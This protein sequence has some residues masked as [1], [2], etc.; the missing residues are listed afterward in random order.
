MENDTGIS[1]SFYPN[2][3]KN[4]LYFQG[5]EDGSQVKIYSS[6]GSLIY[7]NQLNNHQ[8]EITNLEQGIYFIY[9]YQ[10]DLSIVKKFVKQ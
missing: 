2:P 5:V 8:L 3:S 7:D 6:S 4:I 9:I 1:I 10:N